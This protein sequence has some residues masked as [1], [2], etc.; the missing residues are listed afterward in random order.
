MLKYGLTR[1]PALQ[2]QPDVMLCQSCH[3]ALQQGILPIRLAINAN[4]I[5][6]ATYAYCVHLLALCA[7]SVLPWVLWQE[8]YADGTK[9]MLQNWFD[10]EE[11]PEKWYIVRE[12]ELA[13]QY[14]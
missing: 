5:C 14:K 4:M 12:G 8:R 6:Y 11:F 3:D 13:A 9:K 1:L 10:G 7:P 2:Q